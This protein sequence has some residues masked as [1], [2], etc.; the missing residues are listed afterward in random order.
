MAARTYPGQTRA[1]TTLGLTA[2][3]MS[4]EQVADESVDAMLN[5]L[6]SGGDDLARDYYRAAFITRETMRLGL[7]VPLH[8][9]AARFYQRYDAE[10]SSEQSD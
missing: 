8:P 5:L 4:R 3:L 1:F 6:L 2:A 7:E 9:A 10:S